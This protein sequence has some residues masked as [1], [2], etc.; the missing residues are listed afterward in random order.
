MHLLSKLTISAVSLVTLFTSQLAN[1]QGIQLN[2]DKKA[3]GLT[4]ET[5]ADSLPTISDFQTEAKQAILV[6]FNTDTVLFERESESKM[7]PSSMTKVLTMY[8]VFDQ[9]RKGH[10]T[11]DTEFPVSERSWKTGGSQMF[12]E[13][14]KTVKVSDLIQGVIVQSGNDACVALAEGVSG[15]VEA[16]VDDMNSVAAQLGM[17]NTHFQNPDGLPSDNHFSSAKDLSIVARKLITDFPEYFHYY[18]QREFTFNKIRQFNRNKLLDKAD[19]GVDGMKTGYTEMGGYG[20][21]ATG[22]KDNRRL[23]AVVNGLKTNKDRLAA[24]E[25]L[26]RY[27]YSNFRNIKLFNKFE[28]LANVGVWGGEETSV[29]AATDSDI[30]LLV[31]R[32]DYN[33]NNIKT[34]VA[35]KSPWVAPIKKGDNIATLVVKNQEGKIVKQYPLYATKDV[36]KANIFMQFIQKVKFLITGKY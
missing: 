33:F 23:I 10:I 29:P 19:L 7:F 14:G 16:F 5:S 17:K 32:R 9:L 28:T 30:E 34:F 1:A 24:A 22:V 8:I 18:S 20:L 26:L 36:A 13:V 25:K 4:T 12:L 31:N 27:G 3:A 21:I 15:S 2:A 11:M 35:Y 6:D